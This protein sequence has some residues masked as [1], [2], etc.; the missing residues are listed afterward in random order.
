M[1]LAS[2]RSPCKGWGRSTRSP[3][4]GSPLAPEAGGVMAAPVPPLP[5]ISP[6]VLPL[7]A[8]LPSFASWCCL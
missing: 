8:S 3:A 4:P 1:A 5:P 6:L 2:S 7:P